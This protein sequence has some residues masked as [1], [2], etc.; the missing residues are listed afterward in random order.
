MHVRRDILF[1]AAM[2][3]FLTG[4]DIDEIASFG[5]AHAYEKDFHQ[6]YPLKAGGTLSLDSFNG[7]VEI[8]GWDED[9]VQVDGVQYGS[10]ERLRDAISIDVVATGNSVQIRTIRPV[11]SRGNMGVKYVIKAP[12]KVNLDRIVTSNGAV[13]VDDLEGLMR[14]RTSNGSVV[15]SRVSGDVEVQTSNGAV[16]VRSIDGPTTIRTSNGPIHVDGVRGTLQATTSNGGIHARLHKPEPSRTVKLSTS[17][18]G[19]DLT[20]DSLENNDIRATTSNGGITLKLPARI[21]AR[22]RAHTSQSSIHTDFDVNREEPFSKNNLQGVIGGGGPTLELTT[23][24][25]SIR[26]L[27]L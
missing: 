9:K 24:N 26:L 5:N 7:S 15:A 8:S 14:I 21:G 17:N 22:V 18:G 25:G 27:K 19:I 4:C 2:A 11:D 12:R 3:T 20:M 6:H 23:S 16:E 10:T 13:K 1:L